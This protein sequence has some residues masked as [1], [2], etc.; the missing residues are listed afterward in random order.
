M[1]TSISIRRA[2]RFALLA[3]AVGAV[4]APAHSQDDNIQEVIVTGTRIARPDYESASPIVSISE[5]AFEK[6]GTN[7]VDTLLNTLPQFVPS[8]TSTSNNPSNNGQ[9]NM[10]LRG[11]GIERTL[12]LLDGKRVVP[13]GASGAV[14]LNLIPA[15]IISSVEIISGGASAAYGSDAVAG[16]VNI[17]TK[18]FEGFSVDTNWGQTAESDGDEWTVALT[19][20]LK[21]AEGRGKIMGNVAY[22]ERTEVMADDR[23]FSTVAL[24]YVDA[25]TGFIPQGSG[26]IEEGSVSVAGAAA[27][28]EALFARYGTP[29]PASLIGNTFTFNADGSLFTVGD[30]ETPGSV[31]NYRGTRN[32]FDNSLYTYNFSPANY[33]QLPLERT[34][35]FG[36][37]SFEFSEAAELYGQV[38]FADYQANT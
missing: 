16:V 13:S 24:G 20:G 21:F 23:E 36:R 22:S 35:A 15:S 6:T 18:D 26:T 17:K 14:D 30:G 11:L 7:T 37:A 19:A 3:G 1:S 10:E 29:A 4:S 8:V 33:L 2:V 38:I 34:T 27:A 12:V 28:K 32:D 5:D 9:A 31:L 25:E